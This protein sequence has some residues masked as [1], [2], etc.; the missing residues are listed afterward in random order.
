MVGIFVI[1]R[2]LPF[3]VIP[4]N[5]KK[6]QGP[7]NDRLAALALWRDGQGRPSYEGNITA[8]RCARYPARLLRVRCG[9]RPTFPGNGER[10]PDGSNSKDRQRG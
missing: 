3:I 7:R 2:R 8:L 9:R 5:G 10:R 6:R 1:P 4:R